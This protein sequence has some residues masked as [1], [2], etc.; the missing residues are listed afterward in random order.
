M[1]LPPGLYRHLSDT[2]KCNICYT[3]PMSTPIIFARCCKTVL[4]CETCVDR[5]YASGKNNNT[6]PLC[7]S[8]RAYSEISRLN[9]LDDFLSFIRPLFEPNN[10]DDDYDDDFVDI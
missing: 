4:G 8:D 6:C 5:W 3:T 9:G 7:R 2:F 1:K 10:K